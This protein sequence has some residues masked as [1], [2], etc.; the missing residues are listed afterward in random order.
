MTLYDGDLTLYTL[1]DLESEYRDNN[2]SILTNEHPFIF[3]E[4]HSHLIAHDEYIMKL[5]VRYPYLF[6][7]VLSHVIK[8][9]IL[10]IESVTIRTVSHLLK[11]A[12]ACIKQEVDLKSM[13]FDWNQQVC[14]LKK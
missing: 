14:D 2:A 11:T 6:R 4:L 3:E 12:F 9:I 13:Q 10:V 5:L 7:G 1:N 8:F